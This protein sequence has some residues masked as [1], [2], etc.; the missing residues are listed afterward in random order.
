M[1]KALDKIIERGSGG[2][3][4]EPDLNASAADMPAAAIGGSGGGFAGADA[5]SQQRGMI[6]F[7]QLDTRKEINP[8]NRKELLRRSRWMYANLG[9][10]RRAYNGV[11]RMIVGTGLIPEPITEDKEWNELSLAAFQRR[12]G[13]A[14][15]FDLA[16]KY[17]FARSQRAVVCCK[18]K[19]GDI[20]VALTNST[21]GRAR[22]G[23]YEAHQIGTSK[24]GAFGNQFDTTGWYDGVY[25][26]RFNAAQ[27]YRIL[28]DNEGEHA[29]IPARDF[30]HVCDFERPG[31]RRGMTAL[32]HAANNLLDVTEIQSFIKMGIKQANRVGYYIADKGTPQSSSGIGGQI[33][34]ALSQITDASGNKIN[35]ESIYGQGGEIPNV[36]AGKE[37]R[38]LSDSRPHPNTLGFMDYL[39][40]D[41]AWGLGIGPELLWNIATLGGA[42]TRFVLADAQG[43]IEEEQQQ[44]ID[45]YCQRVYVYTIAKEIKAGTLRPCKDPDW[46]FKCGWITPARVTVDFGRD[47]TLHLK[48]MQS[49]MLTFKQFYGWKG[50]AWKKQIEQWIDERAYMRDYALR[51]HGMSMPELFSTLPSQPDT[52]AEEPASDASA[53]DEAAASS[54]R[55]D[56][57]VNPTDQIL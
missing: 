34:G 4:A 33:A 39:I 15:V 45:Q 57:F 38:L 10:V 9:V 8:T 54:A 6:Y 32:A 17:N 53:D 11:S 14:N 48:Q 3:A 1:S 55:A 40:R 5:S 27:K 30:I 24:Y 36:P 25:V 50:Q 52:D 20:G 35:I 44:L 31:Q 7:P 43:F 51:E 18:K 21:T 42:N 19:D 41:V 28:G 23:F 56:D 47:G 29:D 49:G 37:L 22:F 12:T 46:M 26:D 16:Q 2:A 13:Q